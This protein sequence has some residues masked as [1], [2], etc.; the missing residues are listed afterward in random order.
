ME[1][2]IC[3][4]AIDAGGTK[5]IA[6]VYDENFNLISTHRTGSVRSNTT[7][8]DV[9]ERNIENLIN[10][11][12]IE[13]Y[14]IK[15]ISGWFEGVPIGRFEQICTVESVQVWG[16][17]ELGLYA[18]E[19]FGDGYLALSGTGATGFGYIDGKGYA[20]GGYGAA[21]SD[22]GSGYWIGREAFD[23]AIAYDQERGESTLLRDLI[24]EKFSASGDTLRNAIFK[25]YGKKDAS[26]TSWVA[27]CAKLV[28][29]AAEHG[30]EIAIA[31]LKEAAQR[32]ASQMMAMIKKERLPKNCPMTISGSVW[33]GHA[34]LINEFRKVLR[35][36]GFEGDIIIPAFEPIVGAIIKHY[37]EV[38]GS[39]G[40]ETREKFKKE[41]SMHTFCV[42]DE[43]EA[44]ADI[45][46]R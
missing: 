29:E 33:R 41:Y 14:V 30:D 32:L 37:Y 25:L 46:Y 19:I 9:I 31:I 43:I 26:P 17:M 44:T 23:A 16:E 35:E 20:I 7:P 10:E 2:K 5:V 8:R 39:F 1:Q 38:H 6:L 15:R 28:S 40:D 34:T 21:V 3:N 18:A 36:L 22:E 4:I 24:I 27:S 42:S 13:G 45:I 12:N 11:M